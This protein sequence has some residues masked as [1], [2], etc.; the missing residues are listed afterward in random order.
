MDPCIKVQMK[1]PTHRRTF[2]KTALAASAV[3]PGVTRGF[4]AEKAVAPAATPPRPKPVPN[5][6]SMLE[7]D[8]RLRFEF[9]D[10]HLVIAGGLQPSMLCTRAGAIIVQGQLPEKPFPSSRMHYPYALGTVVS[11]DGAK[12][13]TT[14]PLKP[15]DN[16]LNMEGGIVQLRDGTILSLDTYIIPGTNR[17]KGIGQ[18]YVS[19]DEWQTVEG[20]KDVVFD[21]PDGDFPSKDDGGRPHEAQRLHRRILELPNGDLLTTY[22]GWKKGDSTPSTY[23][24]RMIK[25][26]VMLARSSDRGLNWK[27]V[28]TVA[29][30]PAVGTEGFGE[31]VLAR[32]SKGPRAGRL[33][34]HMRTGRELYEA[35]SDDEGKT[36]TKARPITI[37]G[38]D[39]N[40]TELWV[41]MFRHLKG[42]KGPLDEKN[43]DELPGA[44][45]DP[46]LIELRSGLLV[47]AFGVRITQKACWQEPR[48]PWNGNYLAFSRDH[49]ATW[50]NVVRM[51][52]GVLTTHYM[53]IEEM[54]TDNTIYVTYDLGGWSRGMN[55]DIFGR[56][57]KVAAKS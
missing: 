36:W 32:V 20:P 15:G 29:V 13:W 16:G 49:G 42:K 18:L 28:S 8:G 26:R 14:I 9:G 31:P 48:H 3:I 54:P 52:S 41:D 57:V 55:R 21:L 39:I 47:A 1:T 7:A 34:C 23:E 2:L 50:S 22:Y 30:D 5:F 33:I 53:A 17:E 25:T 19:K 37:A 11:R 40:R 27:F 6:P 35:L 46:D 12:T 24:P 4:A 44:V 38:L 43:L 45:V 56:F 10:E 51:T